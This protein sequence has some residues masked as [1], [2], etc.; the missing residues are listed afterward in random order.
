[1]QYESDS[2]DKNMNKVHYFTV[3]KLS[4]FSNRWSTGDLQKFMLFD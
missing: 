2:L 1:M 3:D 4:L